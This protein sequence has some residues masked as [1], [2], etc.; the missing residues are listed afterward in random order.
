MTKYI[1]ALSYS[2]MDLFWKDKDDWYK[3]YV[4]GIRSPQSQAQKVGSVIHKLLETRDKKSVSADLRQV[5]LSFKEFKLLLQ[6]LIRAEKLPMTK[7]AEHK[8]Y[9]TLP[10][11]D[12]L[13]AVFD[14]YDDDLRFLT[15]Y[16]TGKTDQY[17]YQEVVDSNEQISFYALIY[18]INTKQFFRNIALYALNTKDGLIKSYVTSRGPMDLKLIANKIGDTIDEMKKLDMW[19]KRGNIKN[20]NA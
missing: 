18:Y 19:E 2:E 3:K 20:S 8:V 12:R 16:K 17:W 7:Y 10:G 9:A 5:L 11:G 4:L 15:E 1:K 14:G 6:L 13:T